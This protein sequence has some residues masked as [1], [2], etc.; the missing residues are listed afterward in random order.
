MKDRPMKVYFY[1]L[2]LP[3]VQKQNTTWKV[4]FINFIHFLISVKAYAN[5]HEW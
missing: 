3:S 5:H 1:I 2:I 4:L